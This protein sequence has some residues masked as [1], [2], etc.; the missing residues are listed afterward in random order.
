MSRR[1]AVILRED[2]EKIEQKRGRRRCSKRIVII[3]KI[4]NESSG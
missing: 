2:P 3:D 4:P 1:V